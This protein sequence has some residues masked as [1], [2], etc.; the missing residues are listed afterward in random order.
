MNYYEINTNTLAIIPIS[1]KIS[2]VIEINDEYMINKS[3]LEI[4]D[5]SCKY[6]G[7]SYKGRYDGANAVLGYGYKTPIY[8][9]EVSNIIFF[10][11]ESAKSNT[12]CW[13]S[14]S[15]IEKI[16]SINDN[17]CIKFYNGYE[18]FI[19]IS[20]FCL[21]NQFIRSMLL[22]ERMKKRRKIS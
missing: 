1:D 11:T 2:R 3:P 6:F 19:D 5:H 17:A 7:S 13:I 16:Y 9:E 15:Q 12:C 22:K 8:I 21:K 18:L 10:P 4:I 20:M 14:Y